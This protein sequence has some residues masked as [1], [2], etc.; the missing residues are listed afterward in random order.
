MLSSIDGFKWPQQL[1]LLAGMT[2]NNGGTRAGSPI[3]TTVIKLCALNRAM[4]RSRGSWQLVWAA[5]MIMLTMVTGMQDA[6]LL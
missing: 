5:A 2:V 4:I 6:Q 3:V 1:F